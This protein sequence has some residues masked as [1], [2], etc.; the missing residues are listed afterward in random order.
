MAR[1]LSRCEVWCCRRAQPPGCKWGARHPRRAPLLNK[2]HPRQTLTEPP[3]LCPCLPCRSCGTCA[4]TG[5][6][7]QSRRTTGSS[8]RRQRQSRTA[9]STT[10]STGE[11]PAV[12]VHMHL[13]V[14]TGA[15]ACVH[16][17]VRMHSASCLL[18]PPCV[19]CLLPKVIMRPPAP[20]TATAARPTGYARAAFQGMVLG[21]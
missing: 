6:C 12:C 14:C 1:F 4:R 7:R 19:P 11:H 13:F 21:C 9:S 5:A 18:E 2:A 16:V 15:R 17:C 3:P 8:R 20:H 10:H